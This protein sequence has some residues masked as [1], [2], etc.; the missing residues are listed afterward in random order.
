LVGQSSSVDQ[1]GRR[2]V[3]WGDSETS[4]WEW[5]EKFKTVDDVFAFSP[6]EQGDFTN[7]PVVESRDYSDEEKLYEMYRKGYPEEWGDKAP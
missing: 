3:R 7:I 6:L 5:G 1:N 2:H 4:H